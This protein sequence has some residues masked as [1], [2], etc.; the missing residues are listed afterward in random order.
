MNAISRHPNPWAFIATILAFVALMTYAHA[1]PELTNTEATNIDN[2]T[3]RLAWQTNIGSRYTPQV[4]AFT[5]EANHRY[6]ASGTFTV[7]DPAGP[8]EGDTFFVFVQSGTVTVGGTAYT[9]GTSVY[10]SYIGAA[11]G[12]LS[13]SAFDPA[14]VAITGGTITGITDLAIADGGTGASTA[15][16]ALTN[17]GLTAYGQSLVDDIDAAAARTTLGLDSMALQDSASVAI[18]G[19]TIS[20]LTSLGLAG[21]ITSSGRSI[22][23][24]QGSAEA[25]LGSIDIGGFVDRAGLWLA[26]DD[27]TVT[28]LAQNATLF[29]YTGGLDINVLAT[30]D[31]SFKQGGGSILVNIDET[32]LE[33]GTGLA[34]DFADGGSWDGAIIGGAQSFSSTVGIT[35]DLTVDSGSLFIDASSNTVTVGSA[36]TDASLVVNSDLAQAFRIQSATGGLGYYMTRNGGDGMLDFQ[37]EQAGFTGY[38]FQDQDGSTHMIIDGAG[39]VGIG[40]PTPDQ[41]LDVELSLNSS[42]YIRKAN[43]STGAGSSSGLHIVAGDDT[44]GAASTYLIRYAASHVSYPSEFH[45]YQAPAAGDWRFRAGAN[46]RFTIDNGGTGATMG[47]GGSLTFADNSGGWDGAIISGAQSFSSEIAASA[48]IDIPSAQ[49]LTIGSAGGDFTVGNDGAS[50]DFIFEIGGNDFMVFEMGGQFVKFPQSLVEFGTSAIS[51]LLSVSDGSLQF[52]QIN[53]AVLAAD[54]LYTLPDA[55]GNADFVMT[56][57]AQTINGAKT[58][59]DLYANKA[60]GGNNQGIGNGAMSSLAAGSNNNISFGL[61]ALSALTTGDSNVAVGDYAGAQDLGTGVST[62]SNNAF[63]GYYAGADTASIQATYIGASAGNAATA[64]TNATALGYNAQPYASNTV[65]LGNSSVTGGRVGSSGIVLDAGNQTIGGTKTFSAEIAANA[66]IDVPSG[67]FASIHG[68]ATIESGAELVVVGEINNSGSG[69]SVND[70]LNITERVTVGTL[71]QSAAGPTDNLSIENVSMIF[72]DTSSN[73]VT[74]GAF[75]NGSA[76]QI[77]H[78]AV[79]DATNN[80]TLEHNEGTANQNI[81]LSSGADETRTGAYGG[82]TLVCDGSNWYEV[83]Q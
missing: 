43:T 41:I 48:G 20:G 61:N 21:D 60:T 7:T 66:G 31:M 52:A 82:W 4:G 11:W 79:T 2:A 10:R 22:L 83:G 58:I 37:G 34:M 47:S 68:T 53:S 78:I 80:A 67:Q 42:S 6:I 65:Q 3:E 16:N 72:I 27:G 81:F 24:S 74:I 63:F 50:P 9:A 70:E 62:Q 54:R 13:S 45:L 36:L 71:T 28:T 56:E 59:R 19:G 33:I 51:G 49:Y 35:D 75:S 14:N 8:T 23:L 73:S 5:A 30:E 40:T 26:Q 18:T 29:K 44:G 69:V 64:Y 55:G 57:G 15:P 38:H 46:T 1:Q 77:L 39:D 25:F 17:L 32:G 76:G 12:N